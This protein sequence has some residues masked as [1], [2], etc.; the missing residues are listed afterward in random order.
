ML[1]ISL[2]SSF[3]YSSLADVPVWCQYESTLGTWQFTTGTQGSDNSMAAVCDFDNL[4]EPT[5]YF[6][7]KLEE[8]NKVTNTMTG[9]VGTYTIVSGQGFEMTIDGRKWFAY[10][11]FDPNGKE[12]ADC[13]R[14]QVGWQRDIGMKSWSCIQGQRLEAETAEEKVNHKNLPINL[15]DQLY[16]PNHDRIAHLNKKVTW[17]AK[18]HSK[19]DNMPLQTMQ[20][21]MGTERGSLPKD[22]EPAAERVEQARNYVFPEGVPTNFDWRNVNGENFD[23]P[24]TD[25]QGC[26]SCFAFASKNVME[27]RVRVATNNKQRPV[28]SVQ[29]MITCGAS[30]NYNQGCS[31]GFGYLMAGKYANEFGFVDERCSNELRYDNENY[32]Q[33]TCPDTR[34]CVRYHSAEY[35][36]LGGYYGAATIELMMNDLIENGPLGIGI[37]V[38]GDF[39]DYASGVW[40]LP[41]EDELLKDNW[42]P[43]VPTNHAVVIVGYGRCPE[44]GSDSM[45]NEGEE[46]LPYWIVKNSW[47]SDWGADGYIRI[48]MSVNEIAVES[49][50]ISVKP[51]PQI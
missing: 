10:Y 6:N 33:N 39:R 51:I 26:G 11:Y 9:S 13:S 28:F 20:N 7:F 40:Y 32:D 4:G 3:I 47:G 48:L 31:G 15:P 42:N 17:T 27:S 37:Y 21:M 43:L 16:E 45:C 5:G 12:D 30:M 38:D 8:K 49:K 46:N 1:R 35:E 29:E 41:D 36:Y 24:V 44:D 34:N 22:T 14:T 2:I 18:H 23:S 19:F 25:Q 50:P